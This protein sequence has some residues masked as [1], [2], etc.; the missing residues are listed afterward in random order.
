MDNLTQPNS[1]IKV[2]V[3]SP[4]YECLV[5]MNLN[6]SV[7]VECDDSHRVI[8]NLISAKIAIWKR[9][10]KLDGSFSRKFNKEKNVIK[11]TRI[12]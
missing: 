12:A 8:G 7:E 11:I 5:K 2:R 1:P 6:D 4:L 10:N 9:T 3:K